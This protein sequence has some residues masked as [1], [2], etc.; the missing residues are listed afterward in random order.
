MEKIGIGGDVVKEF[1]KLVWGVLK[2]NR[3]GGVW[4]WKILGSYFGCIGYWLISGI[5]VEVSCLED[6]LEE[7]LEEGSI[8]FWYFFKY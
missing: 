3:W 2:L 6:R 7:K 1:W 5:F 8:N 4:F